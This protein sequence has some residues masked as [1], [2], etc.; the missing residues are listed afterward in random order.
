MRDLSEV[1]YFMLYGF[2]FGYAVLC[3]LVLVCGS[4]IVRR[5]SRTPQG[6]NVSLLI[7]WSHPTLVRY[8]ASY[9]LFSIASY[10][11]FLTYYREDW[12]IPLPIHIGI[13]H[14]TSP[15]PILELNDF[16]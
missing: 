12:A 10:P 1:P 5:S 11:L 6:F 16:F 13:Y 4:A 3:G 9:P 14:C 15:S 7:A 8:K 2:R